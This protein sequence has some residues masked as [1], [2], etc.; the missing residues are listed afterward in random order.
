M[1]ARATI[2]RVC[3][4]TGKTIAGPA[5][6]FA[7]PRIKQSDINRYG[8]FQAARDELSRRAAT[9]TQHEPNTPAIVAGRGNGEN[10]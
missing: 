9:S 7:P 1:T 3:P 4:H 10:A 8:S 5:H 6:L 2:R